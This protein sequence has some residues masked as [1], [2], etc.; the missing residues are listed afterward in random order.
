MACHLGATLSA[1]NGEGTTARCAWI[2]RQKSR[3][4]PEE[5]R[6]WVSPPAQAGAQDGR[7]GPPSED[8]FWTRPGFHLLRSCCSA[9]LSVCFHWR[10]HHSQEQSRVSGGN[11]QVVAPCHRARRSK[12]K[13]GLHEQGPRE[14][15]PEV[16]TFHRVILARDHLQTSSN[17]Q[18]PHYPPQGQGC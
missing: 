8:G 15:I 4:R 6:T 2:L 16:I 3:A 5:E 13:R 17:D 12:V 11:G 10:D 7:R 1:W 14:N 9:D 18:G